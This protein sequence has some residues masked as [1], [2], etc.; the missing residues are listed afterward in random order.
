MARSTRSGSTARTAKGPN[1]RKQTYDWPR[2][3]GLVR[4]LQPNAVMFSDA[5]PDIRWIG[6][7]RGVAGDTNW[8]TMNPDAV[9]YPGA[10]RPGHHR[11]ASERRSRRERVASGRDRRVDSAGLVLSHRRRC[12]GQDGRTARGPVLHVRR[13]ELEASAE[14]AADACGF[15][16]RDGRGT[17]RGNG[18]SPRHAHAARP[19]A[20]PKRCARERPAIAPPRSSWTWGMTRA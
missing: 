2:F 10:G 19:R 14:R 17:N 18:G 12:E 9:P 8:S 6:N 7:E 4:R 11:R 15:T 1:G 20:W 3:W 13:A 5:G 16:A